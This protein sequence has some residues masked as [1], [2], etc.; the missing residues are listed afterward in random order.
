M[1]THDTLEPNAHQDAVPAEKVSA[2]GSGAFQTNLWQSIV[3]RLWGY[4]FFISYHWASGGQY[5]YDLAQTLGQNKFDC[6]L[7][8]AEYA[9]GDDW[10]AEGALALKNTQRLVVI[11]TPQAVTESKPVAQE[12]SLFLK[13]S[14][15]VIPIVF[16]GP[17]DRQRVL[18]SEL[19]AQLPTTSLYIAEAQDRLKVGPS[20]D[21]VSQL[22]ATSR[23]LRR[24]H[25]R[26]LT[27]STLAITIVLAIIGW[28]IAGFSARLAR[29]NAEVSRE[30]ANDSIR[31]VTESAMDTFRAIDEA[32]LL[33]VPQSKYLRKSVLESASQRIQAVMAPLIDD[34]A[35][36]H[37]VSDVYIRL[38]DRM[39]R[40]GDMEEAMYA[41]R[42][43]LQPLE[44]L[45]RRS[46]S[47]VEDHLKRAFL[48]NNLGRIAHELDRNKEAAGYFLSAAHICESL[49]QSHPDD[50]RVLRQLS[51]VYSNIAAIKQGE[52]EL[53][54][55]LRHLKNG[56]ELEKRL[57]SVK[58]YED[59]RWVMMNHAKTLN[60]EAR[61]LEELERGEPLELRIRA[62]E[63]ADSLVAAYNESVYDLKLWEYLNTSGT[64]H[65]GQAELQFRLGHV[66]QAIAHYTQAI[67]AFELAAR[68]YLEQEETR[69]ENHLLL[70]HIAL[71][72]ARKAEA[73]AATNA[74]HDARASFRESVSNF[75]KLLQTPRDI[76]SFAH[77][78]LEASQRYLMAL[79]SAQSAIDPQEEIANIAI[80]IED[81][82]DS[83]VCPKES[84]LNVLNE[85]TEMLRQLSELNSRSVH[86]KFA[87]KIYF[88]L[89]DSGSEPADDKDVA[90]LRTA[91]EI[92]R[93]ST[94][95]T[96]ASS[97]DLETMAQI[98][99]S[100][101]EAC[102]QRRQACAVEFY[103]EAL[104]DLKR[105]QETP[106]KEA[107]YRA[108]AAKVLFLLSILSS[109]SEQPAEAARYLEEAES[110]IAGQENLEDSLQVLRV[111][112][113]NALSPGDHG[114]GQ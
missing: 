51:A 54:D 63:I 13:K 43:A 2:A 105:L 107:Y 60:L 19:L 79:L 106:G 40:S 17:D 41:Y 16:G 32:G 108:V 64:S 76:G 34:S 80:A 35:T 70:E 47:G 101:A 110:S 29:Q 28:L 38:G 77:L 36:L 45:Q 15:R 14:R 26:A 55:A 62:C 97:E 90:A 3:R 8:R 102:A 52:N 58:S 44:E 56:E 61:I 78:F 99:I 33:A 65:L 104:Q 95:S 30:V 21:V 12:L 86:L 113:K 91:Y 23:I 72:S 100:A 112:A 82:A 5:A 87:A 98:A 66:E 18:T 93:D 48:N 49:Q 39:H 11:A 50:L 109:Q 69:A 71:A 94:I 59:H 9:M 6:F 25:V 84:L 114:A 10:S 37:H 85:Y 46:K 103:L 31:D 42:L 83:K 75:G 7:D 53:Q 96:E 4:D 24:R 92:Y 20:P 81:A 67:E 89:A 111:Q 73:L 88:K 1:A 27:L 57:I 68:K 74:W 22:I